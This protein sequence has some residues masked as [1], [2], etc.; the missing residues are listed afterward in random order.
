[1]RFLEVLSFLISDLLR[2]QSGAKLRIPATTALVNID[3]Y[4]RV[5]ASALDRALETVQETLSRVASRRTVPTMLLQSLSIKLFE[6][7]K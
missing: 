4:P 1:M 3:A 5:D 2:Q 6:G 7:S